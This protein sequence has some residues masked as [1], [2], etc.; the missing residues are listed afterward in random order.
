MNNIIFTRTELIHFYKMMIFKIKDGKGKELISI[1]EKKIG[2]LE[3][4]HDRARQEVSGGRTEED[5]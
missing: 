1:L 3:Y 5:A 2:G 4:E